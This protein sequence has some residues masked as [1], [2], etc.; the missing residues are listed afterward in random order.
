MVR[1]NDNR[2]IGKAILAIA[3]LLG[4]AGADAA[5]A[6]TPTNLRVSGLARNRHVLT[7]TPEFC[8]DFTGTQSNWQIQADDDP[9]FEL[10]LHQVVP[11]VWFWD[12]GDQDKGAQNNARC[13]TL[14]GI[15]KPGHVPISLDRRAHISYWRL[16]LQVGT[17]WGPWVASDMRMNQYPLMPQNLTAQSDSVSSNDPVDPV[18]AKITGRTFYVATNGNDANAGT[19]AAPFKTI[20]KGA[21]MLAKGDTLLVRGGIYNENVLINANGGYASGEPNNP[22]TV[23][24][25]PGETP[26]VRAVASGNMTA[27]TVEGPS[28]RITDWVIDGITVGGTSAAMG[29]LISG[30]KSVTVKNCRLDTTYNSNTLGMVVAF[31]S[32]DIRVTGCKF[33]QPVFDQLEVGAVRNLEIRGNEF[34]EFNNRHCIHAHGGSANNML[35][36]DNYFHDGDPFEATVFLYLGT[37]GTRVVNNVFANIRKVN[38]NNP[39]DTGLAYG[40]LIVR[41][42]EITAENNVFYNIEDIGIL[43]FEFTEY[44]TYRNNIFMKCT[45]GIRFRGGVLPG[46]SIVGAVADYN[47]FYQNAG[48][49]VTQAGELPLLDHPPTGNCLGGVP[50]SNSACDPKFVNAAAKDFRLQAGSA[51]IDA[52]DPLSPVP[53]GGG[54]RVD[55][56]RY[57]FGASTPPYQFQPKFTVG[58]STP[59]FTWEIR[60]IDN[61]IGDLFPGD[62]DFQTRYQVQI[63]PKPTFDSLSEGRPMLDSGM[64]SSLVEGYTVPD[65][66]SLAPGQYYM[67][68]RQWDDHDNINRGAWSDHNFRVRISG[69]PNPPYLSSLAPAAGAVGVLETTSIVVHV[70][71]DGV[72]VNLT[73]VRMFVNGTQVTPA[74]TGNLNDY[75]LTYTPPAPFVTNA[76]VTV[77]IVADDLNASPPTLDS[78][79]SFT[80]RD[81]I[82][83]QA[84]ANVRVIL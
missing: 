40:L 48:D 35:I 64:V 31:S 17:T 4:A 54:S 37:Q 81:T 78:T 12:S 7:F 9:N 50:P 27:F 43:M 45:Q 10:N 26:I 38:P 13:A 67:R 46:S 11:Q 34:T 80:I 21:K 73:T 25:F 55:A 33:D 39:S 58:D 24:A 77:R 76:T 62:T 36:A 2:N 83:P 74:V 57:E 65:S 82:P 20:N 66:R 14:R 16:R 29:Y 53:E 61:E 19:Q 60:D 15:N 44:G 28:L 69:E 49:I 30:V 63:D 70:K 75:I 52:G 42:G 84:P 59:R 56:G 32:E 1:M 47:I 18:P 79:Y 8:W 3:V 51:A 71:D 5:L 23:K 41:G 72:G 22:I 6:Q 68:V